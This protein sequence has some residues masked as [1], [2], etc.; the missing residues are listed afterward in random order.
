MFREIRLSEAIGKTLVHAKFGD[1]ARVQQCLLVF[2]DHTFT[3]IGVDNPTDPYGR[4]TLGSQPLEVFAF[5]D[6]AL[7]DAGII[8]RQDMGQL[9]KQVDNGEPVP[10]WSSVVC[11]PVSYWPGMKRLFGST[12]SSEWNSLFKDKP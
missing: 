11:K 8:S 7:V 12:M 1:G 5:G 10:Y 2:S 3:V 4:S 9:R 6:D